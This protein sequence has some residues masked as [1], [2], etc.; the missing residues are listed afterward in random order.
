M[1]EAI[2]AL[3]GQARPS[4]AMT[5]GMLDGLDAV[6]RRLLHLLDLEEDEVGPADVSLIR[7]FGS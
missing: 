7:Q 4:V 5:P 1:A 2:R 6:N 3:P